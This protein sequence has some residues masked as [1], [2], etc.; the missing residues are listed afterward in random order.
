MDVVFA[1]IKPLITHP[2]RIAVVAGLLWAGCTWLFLSRRRGAWPLA[3]AGAA[4]ALFAVWEWH[5]K[6]KG[7]NIRVDLFVVSPVLLALT[8]WGMVSAFLGV[9][10]VPS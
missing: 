9:S 1:P 2:E 10:R 5:C 6:V 3:I 8:V 7:Y 4:W